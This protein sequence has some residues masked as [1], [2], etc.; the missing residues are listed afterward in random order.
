MVLCNDGFGNRIFESLES[1]RYK[2]FVDRIFKMFYDI[3]SEEDIEKISNERFVDRILEN[4]GGI[5][6]DDFRDN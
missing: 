6:I 4:F 1:I 3:S 5:S 2:C